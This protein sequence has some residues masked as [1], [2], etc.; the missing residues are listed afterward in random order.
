VPD[1]APQ[2]VL[3]IASTLFVRLFG[4]PAANDGDG[5]DLTKRF[6]L[7]GNHRMPGADARAARYSPVRVRPIPRWLIVVENVTMA[8]RYEA[9]APA[10]GRLTPAPGRQ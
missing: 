2:S 7:I 8:A 5:A 3:A 10:A 6:G 1:Y 4:V 9:L